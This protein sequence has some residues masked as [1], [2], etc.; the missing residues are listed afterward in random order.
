MENALQLIKA[1]DYKAMPWKNGQGETREIEIFPAHAEFS[2][3]NFDWR[4]SSAKMNAPSAFS[5]FPGYERILAVWQGEG[6]VLNGVRHDSQA[7][8]AFS[9]EIPIDALPIGQ[10]VTDLGI[11]YQRGKVRAQMEIKIMAARA[12]RQTY[13]LEPGLHFLVCTKGLFKTSDVVVEAGDTLRIQ[14][15]H[16]LH[17]ESLHGASCFHISLA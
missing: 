12:I 13:A 17:F 15:P 14:G 6:F 10:V 2:E 5:I 11:I 1:Q 4:I 8:F 9:G 16:K 3:M 7:P